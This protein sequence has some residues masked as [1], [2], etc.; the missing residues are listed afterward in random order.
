MST[1][2]PL[3]VLWLSS[4]ATL[5]IH[6][7]S[8]VNNKLQQ[9]I[10]CRSAQMARHLQYVQPAIQPSRK[11]LELFTRIIGTDEHTESPQHAKDR[12]DFF[13]TCSS[14]NS[15]RS[16]PHRL[17]TSNT[18]GQQCRRRPHR[19]RIAARKRI[20]P[21]RLA[22]HQKRLA[23]PQGVARSGPRQNTGPAP[24]RCGFAAIAHILGRLNRILHEQTA[25]CLSLSD[26]TQMLAAGLVPSLYG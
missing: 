6:L 22:L 11:K 5:A 16:Y 7:N 26:L 3:V 9:Q 1:A 17:F 18:L 12:L 25:I 24:G 20:V 8:L 21:S 19:Q 4:G 13:R 2:C 14:S 15:R 23:K 10:L